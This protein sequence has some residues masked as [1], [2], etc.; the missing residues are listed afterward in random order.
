MMKE[1]EC[2]ATKSPD[3]TGDMHPGPPGHF[4]ALSSTICSSHLIE[5]HLLY[6]PD[7]VQTIFIH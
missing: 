6:Y 4:E 7:K 3:E 1:R 2:D 5:I